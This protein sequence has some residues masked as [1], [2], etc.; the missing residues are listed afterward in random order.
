MPQKL[1]SSTFLLDTTF[2]TTIP[3]SSVTHNSLPLPHSTSLV[4]PSLNLCTG[5]FKYHLW[6]EK[7]QLSDLS[8]EKA[9]Q[10]GQRMEQRS[11]PVVARFLRYSDREL[12]MSNSV[13]LKG[14]RIYIND[15]L[16]PASQE[17]RRQQL[18]LL[19]QARSEGKIA[20]FCHNKL[21]IRGSEGLRGVGGEVHSSRGLTACVYHSSPVGP[22]A[23]QP[24]DA[25]NNP[26]TSAMACSGK[27]VPVGTQDNS[28]MT[29]LSSSSKQS[30]SSGVVYV[31]SSVYSLLVNSVLQ[32]E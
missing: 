9:H 7:M 27:R 3:S 1:N 24:P 21:V 28:K 23:N 18:P 10:V 31:N 6:S 11:R 15:D 30:P 22:S 26:A 2:Q 25:A 32:H 13:K 5:N 16:C 29:L 17:K 20:Y 19:K 4:Y 12:V 14:T 8:V